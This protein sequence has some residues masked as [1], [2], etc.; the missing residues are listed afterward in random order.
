MAQKTIKESKVN[1]TPA[2]VDLKITLNTQLN[3]SS[4]E[5]Q[6]LSFTAEWSIAA[7]DHGDGQKMF[8]QRWNKD[9]EPD[10]FNKNG[11][12]QH[13]VVSITKTQTSKTFIERGFSEFY[14]CGNHSKIQWLH[15]EVM[16]KR[17]EWSETK[18]KKRNGKKV[19]VR[20]TYKYRWS[21]PAARTLHIIPPP[22]PDISETIA[23]GDTDFSKIF[24][25]SVPASSTWIGR[26]LK[27]KKKKVS[28]GKKGKKNK[29]IQKRWKG[30]KQ[31]KYRD[32]DELAEIFYDTYWE[33]ILVD[34]TQKENEDFDFE[35]DNNWNSSS[36]GGVTFS[37]S[38]TPGQESNNTITI[39]ENNSSW[40]DNYSYTRYI[41]VKS[42]GP[43]GD[44]DWDYQSIDYYNAPAPN[45]PTKVEM[46]SEGNVTMSDSEIESNIFPSKCI[47][48]QYLTDTPETSISQVGNKHVVTINPPS[49][50]PSWTEAMRVP[51]GTTITFPVGDPVNDKLTWTRKVFIGK[52][53]SQR[54]GE[55]KRADI[56]S[57]GLLTPPTG[58]QISDIDVSQGRMKVR[59]TNNS[60]V[61]SSFLVVWC[62]DASGTKKRVGIIPHGESEGATIKIPDEW[63]VDSTDVGVQAVLGD[64]SFD[65]ASSTY[66]IS[67]V[68]MQSEEVW[69]GGTLPK[70]P[71]NLKLSLGQTMGTIVAQWNWDW[72]ESNIA[73]ISWA[74]NAEA[75]ESTNQPSTYQ[76]T[77]THTGLWYIAGLSVGE[78]HVRVRLGRTEGDSTTWS[79]YAI[80]AQGPIKIVSVPDRPYLMVTPSV[81]TPDQEVKLSW[82]YS[83]EDG[84]PLDNVY[85]AQDGHLNTP[86][87]TTNQSTVTLSR[88]DFTQKSLPWPINTPIDLRICTES[89]EHKK[90]EWSAVSEHARFIIA[91]LPNQ[92]TVTSFVRGW[93][94][95]KP[96]TT[97]AVTHNEKCLVSLPFEFNVGGFDNG[98]NVTVKIIRKKEDTIY[99][100]DEN[101]YPVYAGDVVYLSETLRAPGTILI[102]DQSD[103]I[104]SLDD[105]AYYTLVVSNVDKYGQK[106][107]AGDLEI[108]FR[109][110]WDHKAVK[111]TA[112]ITVDREE[113]VAFIKPIRPSGAATGDAC[114]I[115]RLSVDKPELI[116][117]NAAFGTW[118]VDEYPTIGEFG[119]YKVVCKSFNGDIRTNDGTHAYEDY[120]GEAY[121]IDDFLSII[122]FGKD[123]VTLRYNLSLSNSWSKDFTE[124]KYLG[125]AV[126]GDWNPAVSRTGSLKATVSIQEDPFMDNPEAT[127]EA[128]RRL[129]VY[130]G[131]CHVRTPDGSNYYANVDVQED[132]E[133]KWVTTLAK[134]SLNITRVD[135]PE[136]K[137]TMRTKAEWDEDQLEE[138]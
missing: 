54:M 52:D 28:N 124:T 109:V 120:E 74:E 111:P 58:I 65:S 125:G 5:T 137:Y 36:A 16:G 29:K 38:T 12:P 27:E 53:D 99:K 3:S 37:G 18:E 123:Q 76:I 48:Y 72:V 89:A 51:A 49:G 8:Y 73:E 114:D 79:T 78:W 19:N 98:N 135:P 32:D 15:V 14:P 47:S 115:Y 117:E 130:A 132:R 105:K 101:S 42:R 118:Y 62:R 86:I 41:R 61:P 70:P 6:R 84:A 92:P 128:M 88:S 93:N 24:T 75:W 44:S 25:W 43:G 35:D 77:N 31:V 46:D 95:S 10:W 66:N 100:P 80:P 26:D 23:A 112:E 91:P 116:A 102:E 110:E 45:A 39:T 60:A 56:K 108:E 55:P 85:I 122:D 134:F 22:E 13:N 59:A 67:P 34:N 2:P 113:D 126:Q 11:K 103:L 4:P 21:T 97:D 63:T 127:V 119:G 133:E 81:I 83:S 131:I 20:T 50:S 90:S 138:V 69:D 64:Y 96:I 121:S 1:N 129:A 57:P 40:T 106:P 17:N 94:P 7:K 82:V 136:V 30:F 68:Y 71:S 33:T 104:G 9:K 87:I 107:E